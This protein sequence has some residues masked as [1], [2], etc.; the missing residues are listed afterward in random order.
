MHRTSAGALG[1]SLRICC[2]AMSPVITGGLLEIGWI[3]PV[4]VPA[5]F[6]VGCMLAVSVATVWS[7]YTITSRSVC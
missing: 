4:G 7:V 1:N 2:E 3:L 6:E 5:V